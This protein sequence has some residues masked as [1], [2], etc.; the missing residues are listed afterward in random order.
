ME[1]KELADN[2]IRSMSDALVALDATGRISLVN[3]AV[4]QLFGFSEGELVGQPLEKLLSES[5]RVQWGWRRLRQ[6]IHREGVLRE[7]EMT[8]RTKSGEG[9]CVGVSGSL[10]RNGWGEMMGAVL[11]VRDLRETKRRIAEAR[12]AT[13]AARAK[14]RELEEA[15]ARLRQL[16]AE[17][18]QAAKMSSL[19]RLAAGVAHELN[20]PLGGILLY[21]D[22]LLE[23]IPVDDPRR[24]NVEKI[25][26]QTARC[27][28]IV[29][30]LLDFGRPAKAAPSRL[31][32]NAVLRSALSVLEGQEMFHNLEVVWDLSD[33]LPHLVGDPI[34][35][36]QAFTNI[37]LNA[38]D[39]MAGGGRLTIESQRTPDGQGVLVK[40][41]DT[42][43]GIPEEHRE[44]LFEPFFTTKD[45]GTGLGLPITYGI[46]ERH[47]GSID[48]RSQVGSG[49]TFLVTL[50]SMKGEHDSG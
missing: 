39:A 18:I 1:A 21:A 31:D 29:R 45:T 20:N 41:S 16:Q 22:L 46:V 17:L 13:S 2:I 24:A 6:R 14:T 9:I 25:A 26:G 4:E 34:Q 10:L 19:G 47:N 48:V 7:V 32:V 8:W 40:I 30:G 36:Q 38:V 11:V 15:N 44:R 27:R 43:C 28:Q 23:D 12:A 49:T 37:V 5:G 3:D 42:G 35:L 50:R 33:S